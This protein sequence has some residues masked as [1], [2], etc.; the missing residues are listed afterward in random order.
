MKA[1]DD[2]AVKNR[3]YMLCQQEP[4][5]HMQTHTHTHT[6][7]YAH[8]RKFLFSPCWNKNHQLG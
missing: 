5:K 3:A 4:Q 7:T 8:A 1:C 6:H 2:G